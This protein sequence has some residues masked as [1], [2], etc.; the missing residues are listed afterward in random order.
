MNLALFDFDGTITFKDTLF[1]FIKFCTGNGKFISGLLV[2]FPALVLYKIKILSSQKMKEIVL[3]Y[4]FKGITEDKFKRL[5]RKYSLNKLDTI[6]KEKALESLRFHKAND[7]KIVVVSASID[8]WLR[9]WCE[10]NGL[11]LIATKLEFKDK[12]FTGK[13]ATKNCKGT[14]KVNRIKEEYNLAEFDKI[15]AYG[16]SSG[17][18]EMLGIADESFYKFF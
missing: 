2:L 9:P 7:D 4:F 6:V 13:F 14:E 1:D 17:D 11:E 10:K 12:V 3:S 15:Y 16:D 8:C 5:A 18:K